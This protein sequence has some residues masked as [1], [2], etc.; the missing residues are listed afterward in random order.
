M[1]DADRMTMFSEVRMMP[2]AGKKKPSKKRAVKLGI[3]RIFS[4]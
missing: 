4:F 3:P 1:T 2:R